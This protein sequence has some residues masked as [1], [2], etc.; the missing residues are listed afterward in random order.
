MK[1]N[2]KL[3][4]D[5]KVGD[6]LKT[7]WRGHP[8]VIKRFRKYKGPFKNTLCIAEFVDG[9][10]MSLTKGYYYDLVDDA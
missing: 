7:K 3:A 8:S 4:E 2:R 6:T 5:L 1:K 9:G 10:W